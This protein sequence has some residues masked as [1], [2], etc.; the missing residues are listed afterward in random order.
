M[1]KVYWW[2]GYRGEAGGQ[3]HEIVAAHSWKEVYELTPPHITKSFLRKW[4]DITEND[5]DV[6]TATAQPGVIFWRPLDDWNGEY[7]PDKD[8]T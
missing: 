7:K 2:L 4:A 3:T 1:L 5:R 6:A 8:P